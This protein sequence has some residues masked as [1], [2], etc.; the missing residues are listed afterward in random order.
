MNLKLAT[1][2]A[3][4]G[5]DPSFFLK[6]TKVISKGKKPRKW[7]MEKPIN[8]S[9]EFAEFCK[10]LN[11]GVLNDKKEELSNTL[12]DY[13]TRLK[14]KKP[15]VTV[16]KE[17]VQNSTFCKALEA[18]KDLI[19]KLLVQSV[20]NNELKNEYFHG[21]IKEILDHIFPSNATTLPVTEK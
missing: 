21:V 15:D 10:A 3:V 20:I 18:S 16:F 2:H 5:R 12:K 13:D 1:D 4:S 19:R 14:G 9:E 6:K 11:T 17:V 7:A 8:C